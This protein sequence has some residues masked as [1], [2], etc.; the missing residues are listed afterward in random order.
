[1]LLA[2]EAVDPDFV[3]EGCA[4]LGDALLQIGVLLLDSLALE[5]GETLEA[6]GEN[7]L[8]LNLGELEALLQA[9]TRFVGVGRSADERDDL[10][11]VVEGS[12]IALEDVG[13]LRPLA[14]INLGA[15]R[16]DDTLEVEVVPDELE[17][18]KRPRDPVHERD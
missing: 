8:C 3:G 7:C 12:E 14:K 9:C 18:R 16:D 5:P 4:K 13:A 10:V 6:E 11:E 17:E 2:N 15:P 1:E